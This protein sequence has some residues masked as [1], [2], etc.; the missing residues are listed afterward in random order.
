M[1]GKAK[2]LISACLIGEPC[3]YDGGNS[4]KTNLMEKLSDKTL[5]PV[6][7]EVEG[8]LSTPRPPAEIVVDRVLRENG[9]DVT[10]HFRRGAE[11]ALSIAKENEASLA[12]LKSRSPS[13]GCGQVYD[14]TFSA[15]LV[16]GDGIT[17][18][19]LKSQ[20][21]SCISDENYLRM[22]SDPFE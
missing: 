15:T 7:P 19:L 18:L 9:T 21:I 2:V 3:R 6:C 22:Q 12:I 20:G 16:S 17:T 4:I 5:I 10:E 8:G 11:Q 14:G 13:C 1:M